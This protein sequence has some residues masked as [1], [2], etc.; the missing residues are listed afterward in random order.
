MKKYYVALSLFFLL[1]TA[2][3][4]SYAQS[5]AINTDG[6]VGDTSAILDVKSTSKGVLLPRMNTTQRNAISLP[7]EGLMIYNTDYKCMEYYDGTEWRNEYTNKA[8][9]GFP[10]PIVGFQAVTSSNY[11]VPTGK[12]LY[13]T[14]IYDCYLYINSTPV[15]FGFQANYG[16]QN[17]TFSL[18]QPIIVGEGKTVGNCIFNGFLINATIS[19]V[20]LTISP[21]GT[22]T[23]PTGKKLYITSL[24]GGE[25]GCTIAWRINGLR[26]ATGDRLSLSNPIILNAGDVLRHEYVCYGGAGVAIGYLR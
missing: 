10:E 3:M 13:I 12:N 11:V 18:N 1:V 19:P 5:V 24:F 9:S 16:G 4:I 8:I 20:F 7:A 17:L 14:N 25:S 6:S 22:Y 26:I 21:N 23:V 2:N 15:F